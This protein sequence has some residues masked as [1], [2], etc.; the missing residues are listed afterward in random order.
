[1]KNK[2]LVSLLTLASV[3]LSA[4]AENDG[5][6]LWFQNK[7]NNVANV[8]LKTKESATTNIAVRELKNAWGGGSVTLARAPKKGMKQDAFTINQKGGNVTITSPSDAGL[9]YGA[10]HIL[11]L[12]QTLGKDAYRDTLFTETP[13]H[14]LRLLNHWDNLNG[15]VERGYAGKSI[16]W[17]DKPQSF[18]NTKT[19]TALTAARTAIESYARANASVGI[20]GAVINNVNASPKMLSDSVLT[21]VKAYADALRP[22]NIKV[23]LAV[24]FSSPVVLDGLKTADPLDKDVQKWWTKKA[25]EIYAKIPDF[26]GFLVKANSEGQ[27]G[28]MDFGRTHADGANMLAKALKPFGGIVMWRA[29]VY[30]PSDPDRAK[31]AYIE[32]KDLDSKFMDN[33]II[34]IKN[35]PIDFQPREP[36]SPLFGAMPKT[37]EMAELQITQ[38]YLGHSNHICFLGTMWEEFLNDIKKYAN[39]TDN[40]KGYKYRAI[41]GVANVGDDANFCGN[42]M[43][44][45]N[46]YAFGRLAWNSNLTSKAI[47][48]EWVSQN[49]GKDNKACKTVEDILLMSRETVVD[50]MMPL[51]FHHIFAEGHH[52]GPQPWQ[53]NPGQRADWQCVYY[54]RADA[55]GVGFDRTVKTGSGATAQ[56]PAAFGNMVENINTCPDKYLLWFHHADWNHKCQTGRTLWNEMCYRYQ[57][58][59]NGAREMLRKWNSTEPYIDT[60]LFNDIQEKMH[61]Q[62]RDAEWWKD[63]CLN[64]FQTFS[65]QPIPA[66]TEPPVHSLNEVK[67][68]RLG[69]TNYENPS[70]KLLNSRR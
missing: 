43:A 14:D 57:N 30:S 34:Q 64:Y 20:N 6:N 4:G 35:G 46:W 69:I 26:G 10:Y 7:A 27:P 19:R 8:T 66:T 61:I 15:T 54:H 40:L 45:A 38:E 60:R 18:I 50:Y 48:H 68:V 47:A 13:E 39:Y 58:G 51:G 25:K 17:G 70:A 31:Q 28:P 56:Y 41:A 37:Q 1:M 12:E 42:T 29:F 63:A 3:C 62:V 9:M 67:R 23:Y 2:H 59:L 44:Q 32:F 53:N 22:Y 16:F 36:Y 21:M 55:K 49:I 65:H 5:T 24:N 33:V 11:R 52:Y